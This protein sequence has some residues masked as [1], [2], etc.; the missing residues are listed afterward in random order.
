MENKENSNGASLLERLYSPESKAIATLHTIYQNREVNPQELQ[1][2]IVVFSQ[3]GLTEA[4][5]LSLKTA[6]LPYITPEDRS[7]LPSLAHQFYFSARLALKAGDQQR[8]KALY[9]KSVVASKE[10]ETNPHVRFF[11]LQ[12]LCRLAK[13]LEDDEGFPTVVTMASEALIDKLADDSSIKFYDSEWSNE[14]IELSHQI[15]DQKLVDK[16]HKNIISASLNFQYAYGFKIA[17]KLGYNDKAD[18]IYRT[19][20][21]EFEQKG[22]FTRAAELA[23]LKGEK[24]LSAKINIEGSR[25]SMEKHE[26]RGNFGWAAKLASDIGDDKKAR[27]LKIKLLNQEEASLD[28]GEEYFSKYENVIRLSKEFGHLEKVL[29][30][31]EKGIQISEKTES[32]AWIAFYAAEA[33]RSAKKLGKDS[34]SESYFQKAIKNYK[35]MGNYQFA[36]DLAAEFGNHNLDK[37]LIPERIEY[38]EKNN[39]YCSGFKFVREHA[40][41]VL[42]EFVRR[43]IEKGMNLWQQSLNGTYW[44]SCGVLKGGGSVPSFSEDTL[45]LAKLSENSQLLEQ[46]YDTYISH[47]LMMGKISIALKYDEERNDSQKS[48]ELCDKLLHLYLGK[49]EIPIRVKDGSTVKSWSFEEALD[50]EKKSNHEEAIKIQEEYHRFKDAERVATVIGDTE[51]AT[52]YDIAA[53]LFDEIDDVGYF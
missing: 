44:D 36:I 21:S 34:S 39:W 37:E 12:K 20:M 29:S 32:P 8:A 11:T 35:I 47:Y 43:G 31:C 38:F 42:E 28:G 22:W 1:K 7:I 25:R 2:S 30:F 46:I 48:L 40:P 26:A 24:D 51:R 41:E 18:E 49:K 3:Y 16:I 33:A 19:G 4:I 9:Q 15:K 14:L 5:E 52:V 6:F 23:E 50:Q 27:E 53:R 13:E 10:L 45:T 17:Q